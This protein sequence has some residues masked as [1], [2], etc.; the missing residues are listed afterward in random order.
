MVAVFAT[1]AGL[2]AD[3]TR[4]LGAHMHGMGTLDISMEGNQILMA[5]EAPAADIIGFEH[6]ATSDEDK[7]A[8]DAALAT[9]STP[10]EIFAFPAA[11][12][13]RTTE[14]EVVVLGALSRKGADTHGHGH[15][16][17]HGDEHAHD[18][19]HHDDHGAGEAHSAFTAEYLLTCANPD[20][21]GRV[22]TTYFDLF[23]GAKELAV[24]LVS[25][26]G[27]VGFDL[28]PAAPSFELGGAS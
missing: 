5:L 21:L 16:H 23:P 25:A 19:D 14:A 7:A 11:A 22:S 24:Q 27:S 13:C 2:S 18:H 12:E 3:E 28:T 20:A 4:E 1:T 26:S 6:A 9:L 10:L 8:L 17:G 15:G